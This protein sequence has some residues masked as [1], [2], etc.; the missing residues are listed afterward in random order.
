[1][2]YMSSGAGWWQASDGNW[3]P[4]DASAGWW[5]ASDGRWYPPAAFSGHPPS[6]TTEA[7][8]PTAATSTGRSPLIPQDPPPPAEDVVDPGSPTGR[9]LVAR[10]TAVAVLDWASSV[11]EPLARFAATHGSGAAAAAPLRRPGADPATELHRALE[12]LR[13]GESTLLS[14]TSHRDAVAAR[15]ADAG[16]AALALQIKL[17]LAGAALVLLL[18]ILLA[19]LA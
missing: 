4:P 8:R 12:E 14:L 11:A 6:D 17:I 5:Q 18:L 19:L 16:R 1:M 10:A 2:S 3:Y 13:S 15:L 9:T 7:S